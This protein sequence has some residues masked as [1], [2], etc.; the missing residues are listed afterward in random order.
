[1]S[2]DI[3]RIREESMYPGKGIEI[4]KV[5]GDDEALHFGYFIETKLVGVISL[6]K[7]EQY[8]IRK[9]AV[10]PKYQSNG[11]GSKLMQFVL[12]YANKEDVFLNARINKTGFYEK[13]GLSIVEG[14]NFIKNGFELIRMKK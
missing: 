3:L 10:L 12:E 6:F 2:D 14:T 9:M 13:Q 7:K 4:V 1:M 11:I 8:Q 5:D